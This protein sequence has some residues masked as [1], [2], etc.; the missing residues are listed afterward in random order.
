MFKPTPPTP[1][2]DEKIGPDKYMSKGERGTLLFMVML[3]IACGFFI[4]LFVIK[5]SSKK[6]DDVLSA[7]KAEKF[8][9]R[10]EE[11][12]KRNL[13]KG[14]EKAT[15]H[16]ES[17][18]HESELKEPKV[19]WKE[20]PQ[21]WNNVQERVVGVEDNSVFW[22]LV[23]KMNSLS[24]EEIE[25]AAKETS[26]VSFDALHTNTDAYRGKI[27]EVSGR[28][29]DY[30]E[31][32]RDFYAPSLEEMKEKTGVDHVW[33]ISI[34]DGSLRNYQ[35]YI[36]EYPQKYTGPLK[37]GAS[38]SL[39][40][41]KAAFWKVHS[42]M[43][44]RNAEASCYLLV[45]KFLEKGR[46]VTPA[47]T[48]PW[49]L[50]TVVFVLIGLTGLVIFFK[51]TRDVKQE[52]AFAKEFRAKHPKRIDNEL[53]KKHVPAKPAQAVKQQ[54]P[55]DTPDPSGPSTGNVGINEKPGDG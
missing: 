27:I 28:L 41:C 43:N 5:G 26:G 15:S 2:K 1:K 19:P 51:Y 25:A 17:E 11:I 55:P 53:I 16:D 29:A 44:Q 10:F 33:A 30:F 42:F 8:Q 39:V 20:D 4:Y 36:L 54:K 31:N 50:A 9:R 35:L 47:Q 40:R 13:K 18:Q 52:K 48:Y 12:R 34:I 6:K 23:H 49:Q 14:A 45:G 7:E 38:G 22:Y 46:K 32:R 3:M 24:K 37:V 21:I